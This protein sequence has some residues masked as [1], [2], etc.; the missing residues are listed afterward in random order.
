M[1]TTNILRLIDYYLERLEDADV[2]KVIERYENFIDCLTEFLFKEFFAW[3]SLSNSWKKGKQQ[4]TQ[5]CLTNCRN[6]NLKNRRNQVRKTKNENKKILQ[7]PSFLSLRW[8]RTQWTCTA[9]HEN[10]PIS[11]WN[12]S[13]SLELFSFKAVSSNEV[14]M[15]EA[16]DQLKSPM[17][18][19]QS[20]SQMT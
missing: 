20:L 18:H 3:K 5:G 11:V 15:R 17:K 16:D 7:N 14:E 1:Q 6:L 4:R 19:S 12:S 9:N 13:C 8:N 10:Q 2:E